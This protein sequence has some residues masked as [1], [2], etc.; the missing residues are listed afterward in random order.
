MD[1]NDAVSRVARYVHGAEVVSGTAGGLVESSDELSGGRNLTDV[2]P[3][4]VLE[5]NV[6]ANDV[7]ETGGG[8]TVGEIGGAEEGVGNGEE[9]KRG[10]VDE[11]AVDG[12][13]G[14]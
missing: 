2:R 12:R 1:R 14:E 10:A 5:K 3:R 8:G 11:I 6:V 9:S 13:G 7:G 4:K